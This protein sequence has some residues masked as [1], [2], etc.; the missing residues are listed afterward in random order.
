M[1]LLITKFIFPACTYFPP[2]YDQIFCSTPYTR[3]FAANFFPSTRETQVSHPYTTAGKNSSSVCKSYTE[4]CLSKMR[5]FPQSHGIP[6]SLFTNPKVHKP[7]FYK[8]A[9]DICWS[10]SWNLLNVLTLVAHSILRHY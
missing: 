9:S 5:S 2:S 6:K 7:E 3:I 10:S 8:V 4:Q 1:H